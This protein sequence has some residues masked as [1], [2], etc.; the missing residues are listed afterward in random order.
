MANFIISSLVCSLILINC[1]WNDLF[2]I[3]LTIYS[4]DP[5]ATG[6]DP[7]P[8]DC[9]DTTTCAYPIYNESPW[10]PKPNP[11]IICIHCYDQCYCDSDCRKISGS[12]TAICCPTFSCGNA[13]SEPEKPP[14]TC[15]HP[16][17][18]CPPEE[19]I[20]CFQCYDQCLVNTD[21]PRDS[22]GRRQIC[23]P[24]RGCGNQCKL[25]VSSGTTSVRSWLARY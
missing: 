17:N 11:N 3:K 9:P 10:C 2:W 13:C 12:P 1:K 5:V 21:C 23:C 4:L 22:K 25:P 7:S 15:D 14:A 20:Q 6:S 18:R 16:I 24:Q 8:I 19:D